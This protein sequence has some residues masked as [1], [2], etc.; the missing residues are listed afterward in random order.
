MSGAGSRIESTAWFDNSPENPNNPDPT[1]TVRW[2]DQ[3]EEE[4]MIGYLEYVKMPAAPG[5]TAA[6]EAPL[7]LTPKALGLLGRRLDKDKDNRVSREEAG[8]AFLVL[9]Q[10]LDQNQDGYVTGDEAKAAAAARP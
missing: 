10:R 3:T 5:Q 4:M 1:K 8:P 6:A 9:H 7:S 2:G